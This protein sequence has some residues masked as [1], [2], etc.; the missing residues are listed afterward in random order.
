MT[1]PPQRFRVKKVWVKEKKKEKSIGGSR[2]GRGIH[3]IGQMGWGEKQTLVYWAN[4][5]VF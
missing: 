2:G 1:N 3:I 5:P 4:K